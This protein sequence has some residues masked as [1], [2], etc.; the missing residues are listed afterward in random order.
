MS[1]PA[2][3]LARG[4]LLLASAVLLAWSAF[5][6]QAYWGR[7]ALTEAATRIMAGEALRPDALAAVLPLADAVTRDPAAPASLL[8]NAALVRVQG[9]EREIDA[10][11]P[12]EGNPAVAAAEASVRAGLAAA[13]TDAFLWF[14]LAWLG[15]TRDGFAPAQLPALAASYR[16]G[17][18]EGWI[19]LHRN[20]LAVT[21]LPALPPPLRTAAL[22]EFRDLVAS[23]YREG[24]AAILTGPGWSQHD[25]LLATLAPLPAD[26][27]AAFAQTLAVQNVDA[28]VPG[29]PH[30]RD[31][32]WR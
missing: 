22:T 24:A 6:L 18:R 10:G 5:V 15:K 21:L 8:R 12:I 2:R 3:L 30:R 26:T 20:A 17:P 13:P 29:I 16:T 31:R 9:A 14:A 1:L 27:R 32:P 23:N 4:L 25:A 28:T 7:G 19:A 11:H